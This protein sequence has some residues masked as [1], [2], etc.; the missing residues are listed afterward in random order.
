SDGANINKLKDYQISL[1]E[2][3]ELKVYVEYSDIAAIQPLK[4]DTIGIERVVVTDTSSFKSLPYLSL[5]TVNSSPIIPS[6]SDNQL[7]SIAKVAGFDKAVFGLKDTDK[8]PLLYKLTDNI[9]ISTLPLSRYAVGRFMPEKDWQIA[10]EEI[11]SH[12]TGSTFEFGSW[13]S[14]VHPSFQ[15]G[16]KLSHT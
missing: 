2:E 1:I 3:K 15:K 13:L 16:E 11:L 7:L 4:V 10:W 12:L 6:T 14:Y 8:L 5:L 9:L